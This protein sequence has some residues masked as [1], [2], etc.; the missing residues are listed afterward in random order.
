MQKHIIVVSSKLSIKSD[1]LFMYDVTKWRRR[2]T[3]HYY[4]MK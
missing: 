4:I 1:I 2:H 3:W